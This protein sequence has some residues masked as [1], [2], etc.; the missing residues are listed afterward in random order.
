MYYKLV[1]YLTIPNCINYIL[2][3]RSYAIAIPNKF[4][5]YINIIDRFRLIKLTDLNTLILYII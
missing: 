2:L 4:C 1:I 5:L 3:C